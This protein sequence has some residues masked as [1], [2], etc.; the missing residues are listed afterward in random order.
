MKGFAL[1]HP[2]EAELTFDGTVGNRRFFLVDG[3]G[4]RP[5]SSLTAWR[6]LVRGEYDP[7]RELLR[8]RFPDGTEV[9]GSA[10]ALGETVHIDF[11]ER[12]IAAQVVA[13]P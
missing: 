12:R 9:E 3:E 6:C 2:E 8:M 7:E 4:R 1:L 5:R 11:E 13:G 10:V